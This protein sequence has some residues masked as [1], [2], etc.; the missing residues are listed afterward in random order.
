MNEVV[1]R[2][3]L[4]TLSILFCLGWSPG[5]QESHFTWSSMRYRQAVF[6]TWRE[7]DWVVGVIYKSQLFWVL[8]LKEFRFWCR[9]WWAFSYRSMNKGT[10]GMIRAARRMLGGLWKQSSLVSCI[11]WGHRL[12]SDITI[13]IMLLILCPR[14]YGL[15]S[16]CV[17]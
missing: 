7:C 2:K 11:I 9:E 4:L 16:F 3:L 14:Q 17:V 6:W 5:S 13:L 12:A 15:L 10:S 8:K 1:W